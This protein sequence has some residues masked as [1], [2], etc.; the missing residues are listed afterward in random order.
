MSDLIKDKIRKLLALA[1]SDSVEE[2]ELAMVKAQELMDRYNLNMAEM[3]QSEAVNIEPV[4][5]DKDPFY[6][7][8]RIRKWKTRLAHILATHNNCVILTFKS[9]DRR[10]PKS[11]IKIFGRQADIDNT[12][13]LFAYALTQLTKL[14]VLPCIGSGIAYKDSWYTGAVAGIHEK[15]KEMK[16]KVKAEFSTFAIVKYDSWLKE[17]NDFIRSKYR[18]TTAPQTHKSLNSEAYNSGH[19]AGREIDLGSKSRLGQKSTIGMIK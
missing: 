9:G 15:L 17:T 13:F 3:S 2:A 19:K 18:V 12:R 4:I 5:E 8:G 16:A 6:E 7:A 11:S 10:T 1:A 14:S